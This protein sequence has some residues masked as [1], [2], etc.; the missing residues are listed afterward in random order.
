MFFEKAVEITV[1]FCHAE[2]ADPS[3]MV[4]EDVNFGL[5]ICD[6]AAVM[7]QEFITRVGVWGTVETFAL[8]VTSVM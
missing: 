8:A 3:I 2:P 6:C 1:L 5:C 7:G 4:D